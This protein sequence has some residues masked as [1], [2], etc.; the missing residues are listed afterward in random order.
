MRYRFTLIPL[1]LAQKAP[2][3]VHD[4]GCVVEPDACIDTQSAG[5]SNMASVES[6]DVAGL[7]PFFGESAVV[8]VLR[9]S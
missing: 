8:D 4:A 1:C 2:K 5:G 9:A 3:G 7:I 6:A